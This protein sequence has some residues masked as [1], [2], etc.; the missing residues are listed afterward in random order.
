MQ[1]AGCANSARSG[2]DRPVLDLVEGISGLIRAVRC[3][4]HNK[5]LWPELGMR[6]ADANVL[7]VLATRGEMRSGELAVQ[8]GVDASVVSRQLSSL[9]AQGFV[10]RRP[11]P[12][13]ARVSLAALSEAGRARV[14]EIDDAFAARLRGAL[15]EWTDEELETTSAVLRQL[16]RMMTE[17]RPPGWAQSGVPAVAP[18]TNPVASNGDR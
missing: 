8:L 17:P 4:D 13:D 15:A 1:L 14:E 7:R 18:P 11:D 3:A 16:A 5:H 12:A 10:V 9:E 6:R 2:P